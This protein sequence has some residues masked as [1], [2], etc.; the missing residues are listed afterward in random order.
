M[1]ILVYLLVS[2]EDESREQELRNR[3]ENWLQ[4]QPS[5]PDLV[6]LRQAVR[7]SQ[8]RASP[9]QDTVQVSGDPHLL[10]YILVLMFLVRRTVDASIMG[11]LQI[12][13]DRQDHIMYI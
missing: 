5:R 6:A 11:L 12:T 9:D 4:E 3:L 10:L 13:L 8:A 7:G 1:T 2:L